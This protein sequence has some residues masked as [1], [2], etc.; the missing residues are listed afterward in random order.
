MPS[1]PAILL[2]GTMTR[3]TCRICEKVF[4]KVGRG[5][6]PTKCPTC[7]EQEKQQKVAHRE[8]VEPKITADERV[9]RL[10]ILL[11]SKGSHISQHQKEY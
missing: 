6:N 8:K 4:V 9:T 5:R 3:L 7:K 11:K 2:V 1:T 10:E